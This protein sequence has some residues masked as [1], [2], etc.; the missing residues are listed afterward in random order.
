[1]MLR[2]FSILIIMTLN[3]YSIFDCKQ[4]SDLSN[5]IVI[6]D[7]VMGG[8]SMGNIDFDSKGHAVFSGEVS[9][10]NNGGFSS[11]RCRFES[12]KASGFNRFVVHLKGDGK[13]YQFR[14]KTNL[15][16]YYSYVYNFKTSGEWETVE[17]PFNKMEPSF[18]GRILDMVNFPG[19]IMEEV[20]FL[21]ANKEAER[22]VLKID[23]IEL[24]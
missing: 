8:R 7:V 22:F 17:I 12:L 13:N 10:E 6:D 14:T 11:V 3:S 19:E 9:L 20:G 24:K 4:D 5:W 21:I 2:L 15:S 23:K 1:M 16:D 18:R